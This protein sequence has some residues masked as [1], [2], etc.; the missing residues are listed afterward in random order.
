M[1]YIGAFYC[2]IKGFIGGFIIPYIARRMAKVLPASPA[3]IIWRLIVPAKRTGYGKRKA[4]QKYR[5]LAVSYFWRSVVFGLLTG[6]LFVLT[7][8]YFDPQSESAMFIFFW[9]LILL[10]EIDYKTYLLPDAVTIPLLIGGFVCSVFYGLPAES[11]LGAAGGYLL[12]VVAGLLLVWKHPDAFGGGDVKFLAAVGAW[13]GLFN[14]ICTI[15]LSSVLFGVF[16]FV[17]R[18]RA[19]AFGPAIS[20]AAI[21]VAFYFF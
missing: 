1:I 8:F 4:N 6:L 12:P 9:S 16:A 11:A 20:L 3:E 5:A 10:A 17:R 7:A 18:R 21:I 2:F 14:V 13:L 19:G 15:I